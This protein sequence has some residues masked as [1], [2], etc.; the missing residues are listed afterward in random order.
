MRVKFFRSCHVL[1]IATLELADRGGWG[2]EREPNDPKLYPYMY[3][4]RM[5]KAAETPVFHYGYGVRIHIKVSNRSPR[6]LE[7]TL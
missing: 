7:V 2:M 1:Q 3:K 6:S 4:I 5:I